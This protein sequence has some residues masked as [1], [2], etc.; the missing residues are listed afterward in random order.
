MKKEP[1]RKMSIN[2]R[3]NETQRDRSTVH[4]TKKMQ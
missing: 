2:E 1:A 4:A 3:V